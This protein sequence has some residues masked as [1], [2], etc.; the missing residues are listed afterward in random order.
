M[1]MVLLLVAYLVVGIILFFFIKKW[2]VFL[3]ECQKQKEISDRSKLHG[4]E[5]SESGTTVT[6]SEERGK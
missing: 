5:S 1:K 4:R 2:D 3:E 6:G